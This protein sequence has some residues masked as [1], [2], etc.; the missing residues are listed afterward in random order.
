LDLGSSFTHVTC[1][2][3]GLSFLCVQVRLVISSLINHISYYYWICCNCIS[4]STW[5]LHQVKVLRET[6]SV[7]H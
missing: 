4:H 3:F 1:R 5:L 2:N 6:I 7:C